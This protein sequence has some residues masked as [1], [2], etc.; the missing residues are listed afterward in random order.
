MNIRAVTLRDAHQNRFESY[1]AGI[2]RTHP[3]ETAEMPTT[4]PT[5]QS[6]MNIGRPTAVMRRNGVVH[7]KINLLPENAASPNAIE[8]TLE[9][10]DAVY[11]VR[12]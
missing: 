5:V 7:Q 4:F 10:S 1:R 11:G 12:L 3:V 6:V 2:A 9:L 8:I